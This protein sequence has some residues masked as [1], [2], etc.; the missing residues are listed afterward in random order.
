MSEEPSDQIV[1]GRAAV[2]LSRLL[3]RRLEAV[4]K[5]TSLL[6]TGAGPSR[7]SELRAAAG[8]G[9]LF[10]YYWIEDSLPLMLYATLVG[11]R[12]EPLR[13]VCDDT[14]G[15]QVTAALLARLGHERAP[16]RLRSPAARVRD[17]HDLIKDPRA[18]AIAVDGRG[19]YRE[20]GREFAK[21][22]RSAGAAACP[23]AVRIDRDLPVWRGPRIAIPRQGARLSVVMGDAV[24]GSDDV[25]ALRGQMQ[26][27]VE[28][29]GRQAA[30]L[31]ADAA[32]L[33]GQER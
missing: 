18:T 4:A 9:R 2:M 19:P 1:P 8:G 25:D 23:V 26:T 29:V 16:L 7:M 13:V 12:A 28:A 11:A 6:D 30:G 5:E 33:A 10:L 32:P 27:A 20:V 3:H 17:M 22:V 15:G 31:L 24:A 14:F 21:L